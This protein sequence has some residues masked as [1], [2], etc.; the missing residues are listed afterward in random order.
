VV[1]FFL[2]QNRFWGLAPDFGGGA[3]GGPSLWFSLRSKKMI[4]TP[5]FIL[6]HCKNRHPLSNG[7]LEEEIPDLIQQ[8][9]YRLNTSKQELNLS[10]KSLKDLSRHLLNYYQ[11]KIQDG[12]SFS[13]EEILQI[14]R[15]LTAYVGNVILL[16]SGGKWEL[17]DNIYETE[18]RV[19]GPSKVRKGQDLRTYPSYG[20]A[21]G[22]SMARG[23]DAV[24]LGIEPKLYSLYTAA[25]SK[26]LKEK[27]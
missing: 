19:D 13:D 11:T 12:G 3:G 6:N 5:E 24:Q 21:L 16:N 1:P 8:L 2:L 4:D 22:W 9:R 20:V 10:P 14:I 18:I 15:E 23:W 7:I 27:L 26:N 25:I 17:V